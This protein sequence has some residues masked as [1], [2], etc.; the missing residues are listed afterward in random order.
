MTEVAAERARLLEEWNGSMADVEQTRLAA[1]EERGRSM[2]ASETRAV[3][4]RYDDTTGRVVLDL[5]NGCISAFPTVLVEDLQ[6][7]SPE[8]LAAVEVDGLGFNLHW[9]AA[10]GK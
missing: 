8:A 9:P 7:A 1:A 4:A 10:R 5:T 6:S 2:L 3:A